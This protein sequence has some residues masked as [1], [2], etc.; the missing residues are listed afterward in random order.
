IEGALADW[1]NAANYLVVIVGFIVL[2]IAGFAWLFIRLFQ[3][4]QAF[5]RIRAEQAEAERIREQNIRFNAALNNMS[6]GL[7][8]FD[9]SARVVVCNERYLQMYNLTPEQIVPGMTLADIVRR[10][11]DSGSFV[12]D[13]EKYCGDILAAI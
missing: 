13:A 5:A 1:R 4:H 12:G 10:R 3:N 9:A 7:L 11:A 2:G 8:M 6:Q